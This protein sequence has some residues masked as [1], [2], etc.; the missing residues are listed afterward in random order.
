MALNKAKKTNRQKSPTREDIVNS[1]S[2]RE[3]QTILAIRIITQIRSMLLTQKIE[4]IQ[5]WSK[6]VAES[7]CIPEPLVIGLADTEVRITVGQIVGVPTIP[8]LK[9]FLEMTTGYEGESLRLAGIR[10][11]E[12][13]ITRLQETLRL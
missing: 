11:A 5:T 4:N 1:L 9:S 2:L 7:L 13:T 8:D 10:L 6:E 3:L 12:S